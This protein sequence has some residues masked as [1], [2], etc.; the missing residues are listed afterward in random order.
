MADIELQI[1]DSPVRLNIAA[2]ALG[3]AG[4]ALTGSY[5]NPGLDPSAVAGYGDPGSAAIRA[6]HNHE[7]S[8]VPHGGRFPDRAEVAF[9]AAGEATRRVS[10]LAEMPN[11]FPQYATNDQAILAGQFFGG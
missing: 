8:L 11:P 1:V 2:T 5:P 10:L 9:I 6:L 7:K 4:G 3:P